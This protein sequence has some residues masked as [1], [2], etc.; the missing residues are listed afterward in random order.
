MYICMYVCTYVC[1]HVCMYVRTYVCRHERT[2]VCMYVCTYVCMH[3]RMYVCMHVC[4]YVRMYACTYVCM[5]VSEPA[6]IPFPLSHFAPP[7]QFSLS[8]L[9]PPTYRSDSS[10]N[11]H[12]TVLTA[13]GQIPSYR[14]LVGLVLF[15]FNSATMQG[16]G[17]LCN[18]Q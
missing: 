14:K 2:D 7:L 3:V 15:I 12:R 4:M 13:S 8:P 1:M 17:D 6:P 11:K 9:I 10:N 16:H 18:L 5:Y